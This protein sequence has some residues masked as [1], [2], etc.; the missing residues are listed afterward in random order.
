M[1]RLDIRWFAVFGL[2]SAA[3]VAL[4]SFADGMKV[5]PGKWR[6]ETTVVAPMNPP[7]VQTSNE[8]LSDSEF[9]PQFFV[10]KAKGCTVSD[11]S[12]TDTDMKWN[13]SC[14]IQGIPAQGKG[15]IQS[16]GTALTGDMDVTMGNGAQ[17]VSM[18]TSWKGTHLGDCD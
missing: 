2:L 9:T 18:T 10:E 1:L 8:C 15:Q 12:Y 7:Q 6:I 16:T 14:L 3:L 4:P 13:M 11:S 5:Q 17:T